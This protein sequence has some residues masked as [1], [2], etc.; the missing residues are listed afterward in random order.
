MVYHSH[1]PKQIS[2]WFGYNPHPSLIDYIYIHI[3]I[4]MYTHPFLLR[5]ESL[6]WPGKLSGFWC[7]AMFS[8]GSIPAIPSSQDEGE[9]ETAHLFPATSAFPGPCESATGTGSC[10]G[11]R[12]HSTG[13]NPPWSMVKPCQVKQIKW[14]FGL[15]YS[16]EP[17]DL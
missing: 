16:I 14:S 7:L 8:R 15:G 13:A 12:A 5:L 3:H 9:S 2:P 11:H 6:F 10:G 1:F 17:W 4:H